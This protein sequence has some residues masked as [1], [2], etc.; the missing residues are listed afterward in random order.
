MKFLII[1]HHVINTISFHITQYSFITNSNKSNEPMINETA[2]IKNCQYYLSECLR[3][4]MWS[5][6]SYRFVSKQCKLLSRQSHCCTKSLQSIIVKSKYSIGLL[7]LY[8]GTCT[9]Q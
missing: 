6:K 2:A 9:I 7:V 5:S 8:S 4:F 3:G 1:G